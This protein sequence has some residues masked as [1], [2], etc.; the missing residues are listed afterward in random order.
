MVT[1]HYPEERF[2]LDRLMR[3]RLGLL[4]RGVRRVET[5]PAL[6]PDWHL[7]HGTRRGP[8]DAVLAWGHK[9]SA[10]AARQHALRHRLPLIRIED[11][12]LRSVE[13]GH[14]TPPL[15]IVVD[16]LG[17]YYDAS[18]PSRLETL[19]AHGGTPAQHERAARLRATWVEERVSKYNHARLDVCAT[20]AGRSEGHV[21]VVDQTAGDASITGSGASPL[22][23][24]TMLE[25]ALD[26][27]PQA[28]IWLKV[29]PDVIAGRKQ[30]HFE[31]LSPGQ[32]ARI[33]VI[34]E[35][36]HPPALFEACRAVYVVSS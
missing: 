18:T 7:V 28:Q 33:R 9:P 4:T 30:G 36:L 24:H 5:L 34:S 29:H 13:L 26:E 11:G 6:L 3:P 20:D 16:D 23:F 32:S 1:L 2:A 21:L 15:S 22:H 35:D 17:I 10:E 14:R 31:T 8:L 19:I 12:F 25:A 27:H